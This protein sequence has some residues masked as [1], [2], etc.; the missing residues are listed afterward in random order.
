MVAKE[1]VWN[2]GR[3]DLLSSTPLLLLVG[4]TGSHPDE[5]AVFVYT[6]VLIFAF[7]CTSDA[8]TMVGYLSDAEKIMSAETVIFLKGRC[9]LYRGE[10]KSIRVEEVREEGNILRMRRLTPMANSVCVRPEAME[11]SEI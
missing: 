3:R 4:H 6:T 5:F 2:R 10:M 9:Q 1:L 8:P 7:K 11:K